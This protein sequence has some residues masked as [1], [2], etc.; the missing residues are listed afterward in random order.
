MMFWSTR[1]G[2]HRCI[3]MMS[4]VKLNRG[5]FLSLNPRVTL[6]YLLLYYY[7]L[8]SGLLCLWMKAPWIAVLVDEGTLDY[9]VCG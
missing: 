8:T 5:L 9:C 7:C 6:G 1:E 4:S 3:E 2:S